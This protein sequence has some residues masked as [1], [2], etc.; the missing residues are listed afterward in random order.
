MEAD[1]HSDYMKVDA[2]PSVHHNSSTF[3]LKKM[4]SL[5]HTVLLEDKAM[6]LEH[7]AEGSS[8]H[9]FTELKVK[10]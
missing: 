4:K 8:N 2:V 5:T 9:T 3:H 10:G 6:S 1:L 7:L